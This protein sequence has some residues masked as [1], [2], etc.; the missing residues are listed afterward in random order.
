MKNNFLNNQNYIIWNNIKSKIVS[1]FKWFRFLSKIN[2]FLWNWGNGIIS[3]FFLVFFV[4]NIFLLNL[5]ILFLTSLF[6]VILIFPHF[7]TIK[8]SLKTDIKRKDVV[9]NSTSYFMLDKPNPWKE[10]LG[11]LLASLF[12][13]IISYIIYFI[14]NHG[15][16]L[17]LGFI[18]ACIFMTKPIFKKIWKLI[19]RIRLFNVL[20]FPIFISLYYL[21]YFYDRFIKRY[22]NIDVIVENPKYNWLQWFT[23]LNKNRASNKYY[24]VKLK[25]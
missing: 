10:A 2:S 16:F 6:F 4:I 20:L 1:Q 24:K 23:D 5:E 21:I 8:K 22:K 14:F 12:P 9:T 7:K 11:M 18:F 3:F 17:I 19:L 15:L 13:F 25:W